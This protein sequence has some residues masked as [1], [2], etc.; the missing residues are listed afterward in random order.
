MCL[1]DPEYERNV[2]EFIASVRRGI[3]IAEME[4]REYPDELRVRA[5]ELEAALGGES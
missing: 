3:A 1:T 4:G 5:L 2:A